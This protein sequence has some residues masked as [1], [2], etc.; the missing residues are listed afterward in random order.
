MSRA[1]VC[2]TLTPG[3]AAEQIR[4]AG[5]AELLTMS[6]LIRLT[7]AGALTS[8]CSVFDARD[9]DLL[10]VDRRLL[11]ARRGLGL[12]L[13]RVRLLRLF[14]L[15][16]LRA[17]RQGQRQGHHHGAGDGSRSHVGGLLRR[18]TAARPARQVDEAAVL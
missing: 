7:D 18:A 5:G 10:L 11:L 13:G 4:V 9:D 12:L 2:V 15:R 1:E 3:T 16:L 14:R 17:D 6:P 8:A